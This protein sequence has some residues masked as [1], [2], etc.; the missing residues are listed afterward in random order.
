MGYYRGNL[1]GIFL[2]YSNDQKAQKWKHFWGTGD[3]GDRG[4][5]GGMALG[6]SIDD[7]GT[8]LLFGFDDFTGRVDKD[9]PVPFDTNRPN[10][11]SSESMILNQAKYSLGFRYESLYFSGQ[12]DAHPTGTGLFEN[13]QNYIHKRISPEAGYFK[14]P[15]DRELNF[16]IKL[17][18]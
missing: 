7:S 17:E 13:G 11:Q 10:P 4:W 16:N 8:S 6:I 3:G 2:D 1:H 12:W 9:D 18:F 14:Y 5:T 15:A